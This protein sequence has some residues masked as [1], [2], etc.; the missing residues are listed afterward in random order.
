MGLKYD[1][2]FLREYPAFLR[3]VIFLLVLVL[4]WLPLAA[5]FYFFI[6]DRNF[7]SIITLILL[8][9]EFIILIHFWTN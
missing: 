4:L 7:V 2:E 3:I 8:Y 5:P 1:L 6:S 9:I